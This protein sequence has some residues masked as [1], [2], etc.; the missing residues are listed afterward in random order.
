MLN[1][2]LLLSGIVHIK[3]YNYP[4][5]VYMGNFLGWNFEKIL[6]KDGDSK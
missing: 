6:F 3:S 2:Y 4:K 5:P 1:K